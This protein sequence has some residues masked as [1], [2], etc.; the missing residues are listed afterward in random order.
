MFDLR[1]QEKVKSPVAVGKH[2]QHKAEEAAEMTP[3]RGTES[4]RKICPCGGGCPRC[5]TSATAPPLT[6]ERLPCS[7][8]KKLEVGAIED[9][10]ENEAD[11]VADHVLAMPMHPDIG[12]SSPRI[13]RYSSQPGGEPGEAPSSVAQ[14]IAT[15]GQPLDSGTRTFMESRFGYDFSGVRVHSGTAAEQSARDVHAFAYTVGRDIV[16]GAGRFA[17][18]THDGRRLIAHEL[19][20]VVQSG[21]ESSRMN[22]QTILRQVDDAQIEAEIQTL[23]QQLILPVN[24]LRPVQQARLLE[25][26]AM[27]YRSGG[28]ARQAAPAKPKPRLDEPFMFRFSSAWEQAK[29]A[30]QQRVREADKALRDSSI[31]R[32]FMHV[33]DLAPSADEVWKTGIRAGLFKNDE[34]DQVEEFAGKWA[35]ESYSKRYESAKYGSIYG[36]ERYYESSG[37]HRTDDA[38]IWSR[39]RAYGLFLSNEKAAVL[40]IP[41]ISIAR[42]ASLNAMANTTAP[43]SP[44]AAKLMD[45][46]HNFT[47]D[48]GVVLLGPEMEKLFGEYGYKYRDQADRWAA[49]DAI[50][51]AYEQQHQCLKDPNATVADRWNESLKKR[52]FGANNLEEDHYN[53]DCFKSRSEYDAESRRRSRIY[54]EEKQKCQSERG[55]KMPKLSR[56]QPDWVVCENRVDAEFYPNGYRRLD[57]QRTQANNQLQKIDDVINSGAIATVGRLAGYTVAKIAGRDDD[58]A[59]EWSEKGALVGEIGDFAL[60]VKAGTTARAATQNYNDGGGH[61]VSRDAQVTQTVTR[62][63]AADPAKDDPLAG[64]DLRVD[65]TGGKASPSPSIPDSDDVKNKTQSQVPPAPK[66]AAVAAPKSTP[67]TKPPTTTGGTS[68]AAPVHQATQKMRLNLSYVNAAGELTAD[69]IKFLKD[70]YPEKFTGLDDK[71]IASKFESDIKG[72]MW[73]NMVDDVISKTVPKPRR[74]A[75]G[76]GQPFLMKNKSLKKMVTEL[77]KKVPGS[78][79]DRA[80]LGLSVRQFIDSSPELKKAETALERNPNEAVRNEWVDWIEKNQDSLIGDK[81]PDVVEVIPGR[82]LAVV[83]DPTLTVNSQ[84]GPAHAFKTA[85]Y[86]EVLLRVTGMDIGAIDIGRGIFALVGE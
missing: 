78:I 10:R 76:Q 19:T 30:A 12:Y 15:P 32:G 2:A 3:I 69:G 34:R 8:Q 47:Q 40:N 20:H 41:A 6:K 24:P 63:A 72:T 66:P 39:G 46:I 1:Q 74:G 11:R 7:I 27:L 28:G 67:A 22:S 23:R 54:E 83:Y 35:S 13:Q 77:E 79:T 60:A 33:Q 43:S 53:T 61:V 26:E 71:Q 52:G 49:A 75:A 80:P 62:P 42:A 37:A 36:D 57:Y 85:L 16:F 21:S 50:N 84:F 81:R 48:E 73:E 51:K 64:S 5:A 38:E 58:E 14:T 55:I 17:P 9:P 65:V 86:R 18:G 25:L 68:P 4:V 45:E 29:A 82:N 59:L 31:S 56:T 70:K 44:Q